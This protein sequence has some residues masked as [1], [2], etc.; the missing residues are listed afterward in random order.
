[1]DAALDEE[2]SHGATSRLEAGGVADQHLAGHLTGIVEIDQP[3]E[4]L[5]K[6]GGLLIYL[7]FKRYNHKKALARLRINIS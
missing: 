4:A 6:I 7:G 3:N 5:L 2:G 1:M